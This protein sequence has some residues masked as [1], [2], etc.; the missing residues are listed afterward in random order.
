MPTKKGP[1]QKKPRAAK[2][3]RTTKSSPP[4]PTSKKSASTAADTPALEAQTQVFTPPQ[5]AP[6]ASPQPVAQDTTAEGAQP[7]QG[8]TA[9]SDLQSHQEQG[10]IARSKLRELAAWYIN[11]SEQIALKALTLQQQTAAQTQDTPWGPFFEFQ[12]SL[13]SRWVENTVSL[14]RTFWNLGEARESL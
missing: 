9:Q 2:R 1:S 11:S 5:S 7:G 13:T 4:A 14:A 8:E 10:P 12:Y 3:K 6:S